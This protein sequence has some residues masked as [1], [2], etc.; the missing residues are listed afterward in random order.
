MKIRHRGRMK[1]LVTHARLSGTR[2]V[3]AGCGCLWFGPPLLCFLARGQQTDNLSCPGW[4]RGGRARTDNPTAPPAGG[5]GEGRGG[6]RHLPWPGGP[7]S[8]PRCSPSRGLA[9]SFRSSSQ[10][11]RRS[12]LRPAWCGPLFAAMV[13]CLPFCL[14]PVGWARSGG[15]GPP[16]LSSCLSPPCLSCRLASV[17]GRRGPARGPGGDKHSIA[18]GPGG[19]LPRETTTQAGGGSRGTYLPAARGSVPR[20][21][22]LGGSSF[23]FR[24]PAVVR[25][26]ETT[27][28]HTAATTTHKRILVRRARRGPP[29]LDAFTGRQRGERRGG[30][31]RGLLRLA[32]ALL[33]WASDI[34][35]AREQPTAGEGPTTASPWVRCLPHHSADGGEGESPPPRKA[36]GDS[37]L[38]GQRQHGSHPFGM[39]SRDIHRLSAG[40]SACPVRGRG[41]GPGRGEG[42]PSVGV[43][44]SLSPPHSS[45]PRAGL[46]FCLGHQGVC[47]RDAW[48]R[49]QT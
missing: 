22:P 20:C 40:S 2:L 5:G 3:W 39:W 25:G 42:H 33:P 24:G 32:R 14:S 21:S 6:T 16:L 26:S 11:L 28:T 41:A 37:I 35:L 38:H 47:L 46:W 29:C 9:P 48:S 1:P 13:R 27:H 30:G 18:S 44:P 23:A 12:V 36:S 34:S 49:I 8:V 31:G 19:L 45:L 10:T 15:G 4:G 43:G 17:E 7:A